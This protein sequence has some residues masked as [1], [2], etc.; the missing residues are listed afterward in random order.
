MSLLD[1]FSDY[2]RIYSAGEAKDPNRA[3]VFLQR[4]YNMTSQGALLAF[5]NVWLNGQGG[6]QP[7][8]FVNVAKYF[9]PALPHHIEAIKLLDRNISS[10]TR[11]KFEQIWHGK[12]NWVCP[13]DT[14]SKTGVPIL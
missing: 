11:W 1:F 13:A 4:E 2:K 8:S 5:D 6:D 7:L 3:L 10:A 14:D 12:D 9:N